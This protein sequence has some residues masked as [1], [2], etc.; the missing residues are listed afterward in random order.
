MSLEA[1]LD[2]N[3]AA[4][5]ELTAALLGGQAKGGSA[6][7]GKAEKAEKAAKPKITIEQITALAKEA[8]DKIGADAYKALVKKVTGAGALKDV[9]PEKLDAL[10]AALTE[11]RDNDPGESEDDF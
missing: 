3:T 10:A 8:R 4:M 2:A 6:T 11:A 9:A 5:K 7:A 1:A